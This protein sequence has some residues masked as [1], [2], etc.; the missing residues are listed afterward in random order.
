MFYF[1]NF[2][3]ARK[4]AYLVL[5]VG[6]GISVYA[7]FGAME[8]IREKESLH[9]REEVNQLRVRIKTRMDA[10]SQV[11]KSGI[12]LFKASDNVTKGDW[13]VFSDTLELQQHF[14]GIQGI[15]FS[16]VIQNNYSIPHDGKRDLYTS[17][18]YLEPFNARNQRAFGFDMFSESVRREAMT[19]AIMTGNITIS[20]KVRLMQENS[21]DEQPG[22]LM[23]APLYKQ[24][25]PLRTP[26]ERMSAIEGFVYAPFRFKDLLTG[27][28]GDEY[29]NTD[30]DI[31]DDSIIDEKHLLVDTKSDGVW[32]E[33]N[34]TLST[35]LNVYGRSWLL[36]VTPFGKIYS[37]V[38]YKEPWLF[39]IFGTLLSFAVFGVIL[40]LSNTKDRAL[41]IAARMTSQLSKTKEMIN[42]ERI[43]YL[44][45][46]ESASDG[47]HVLDMNG[48]IVECNDAFASMLGYKKEEIDGTNISDLLYNGTNANIEAIF[49][50]STDKPALISDM[51]YIKKNGSIID[52]QINS[53]TIK[54]EDKVFVYASAR[55]ITKQKKLESELKQLN[56]NLTIKVEEET[57][58]RVLQEKLLIQQSKM[59]TMGELLGMIAHQWRQP[60]NALAIG[61]QDAE[62][63]QRDGELDDEYMARFKQNSMSIIQQMSKTID[64][65]RSFFKPT[66]SKE[67]INIYGSIEQVMRVMG[68][69]LTNDNIEVILPQKSECTVYGYKNELEQVLMVLIN[70]A[71][72]ALLD[73]K[74]AHPYIKIQIDADNKESGNVK[75]TVEDNGGGI[76]EDIIDRIFEPY[77]TT[78]EQGSGVGIGLYMSKEII[79]RQMKGSIAVK[80]AAD[81]AVFTIDIP[82][83]PGE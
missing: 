68:P 45:L 51:K 56:D 12:A 32:H 11:L 2:I 22:F 8:N 63:S 31:Y 71:K 48:N 77:F 80:N 82:A 62:L 37:D 18:I 44:T 4:T 24:G 58:K 73:K 67:N 6:I 30:I 38:N 65:F 83:E 27:I 57:N 74:V 49:Q 13:K 36:R 3:K 70:N 20:G 76:A 69:I 7:F 72:D 16:K 28:V 43:R 33:T 60:L 46:M 42:A 14:P 61:I 64:D 75:I 15:G 50:S 34:E 79:E 17:I 1:L 26:Q 9:F 55:D 35:I 21:I 23:Y 40:S 53:K 5:V 19:K 10:Y 25:M 39:L 78:K 41:S 66:K 52:A 47:I 29:A 54:L 81:G 59:A